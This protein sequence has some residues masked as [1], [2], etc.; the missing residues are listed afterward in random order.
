MNEEET[1]RMDK[2]LAA[3]RIFKT[4]SQAAAA[5]K[6]GGIEVKGIKAKPS[7]SVKPGEVVEVKFGPIT[8]TYK[9]KELLQKRV[10]AKAAVNHVEETT[11]A[12]ELDKLRAIRSSPFGWREKGTGRPTKIERRRIERMKKSRCY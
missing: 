3:V 2:W 8:R 11:P 5:C 10:S 12:E 4:R 7:Y 1:V 6:K 9:V